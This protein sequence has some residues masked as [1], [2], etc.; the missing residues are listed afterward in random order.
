MSVAGVPEA[1]L[2][3]FLDAVLPS[4]ADWHASVD[5]VLAKRDHIK[6]GH[7]HQPSPFSS[8]VASG[9]ELE[10]HLELVFNIILDVSKSFA[11]RSATCCL[12]PMPQGETA[13]DGASPPDAALQLLDTKSRHTT[14][15]PF[16][17]NSMRNSESFSNE[18]ELLWSCED[19]LRNDPCRRFTYGITVDGNKF[20]IWFPSRSHGLVSTPFDGVTD[21]SYLIQLFLRLAFA[22]PE[23]LGCDT[24]M[25][26]LVDS[27]GCPQMAL[28]VGDIVYITKRL[29][30]DHRSEVNCGRATRV[31]EAFREDDPQRTPVAVKDLWMP[32]YAAQEGNQLMELHEK[33]RGLT[34]L[35][36]PYPPSRYF[37]TVAERGFV[38]TSDGVDDDTLLM[39][40][41]SMPHGLSASRL[42]HYRI[43]FQQVGT[44]IHSLNSLS[45]VMRA[46]ADATRALQL[47]YQLGFVH[48]DVSAGNILVVDGVGTL[49]DLE[50]MRPYKGRVTFSP[51]DRF[52]GT[53]NFTAGEVAAGTYGY[54]SHTFRAVD[55]LF[56][57]KRPFRHNPFHDVESTLWIGIW[58]L[59]YRR[60]HVPKVKEFFDA[61]FPRQFTER[62]FNLRMLAIC[63]G[64][65]HLDRS[66]PFYSVL[67]ILHD[68]RRQL[69]LR[70]ASFE[71]NIGSQYH[72]LE[73]EAAPSEGSP[74]DDIHS[75]FIAHYEKA[76]ACAEGLLLQA[77]CAGG[78]P[79][80]QD[81]LAEKI[82]KFQAK[83][84]EGGSNGPECCSDV[85]RA[86]K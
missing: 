14:A 55:V 4:V 47:L 17:L 11:P 51:S 62:T 8:L 15:V 25:S 9:G 72:F 16:R 33:L 57:A 42:K 27:T 80:R 86:S 61:H 20:R 7:W 5:R 54:A 52:M 85:S 1:P 2:E 19:V 64:F 10:E 21:V 22:T 28:K 56:P 59:L 81:V 26:Y 3:F 48:R 43:V 73:N 71:S 50:F 18:K 30:S 37:L 23:Q 82:V 12:V 40:G 65:L 79:Q 83:K 46:L 68:A 77:P 69:Y 34:H 41:G 36:L 35:C 31:W 44:P 63:C 32:A 78:S 39:L 74:F 58:V 75:V 67:E 6:Q 66:D 60:R 53:P 49:T 84:I 38:P 45:E 29:L 70:Y 24:T 13:S 76:A